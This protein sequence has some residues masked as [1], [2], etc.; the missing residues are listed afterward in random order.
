[1]T[2]FL[3]KFRLPALS[4]LPLPSLLLA[5]GIFTTLLV[6]A[7]VGRYLIFNKIDAMANQYGNALVNL[8]ARQAV[9][10]TLIHDLVSLQVILSDIAENPGVVNATIHDVENNLLVQAGKTGS[11]ERFNTGTQQNFT[12]PITL[13]DSIAGYVT[14]TVDTSD[15]APL[16]QQLYWLFGLTATLMLALFITA[17]FVSRSRE[18][19]ST[20]AT[21]PIV[22]PTTVDTTSRE[23]IKGTMVDEEVLAYQVE[24][25]WQFGNLQELNAQLSSARFRDILQRLKKHM[26]GALSLYNGQL[27]SMDLRHALMQFRGNESLANAAFQAICCARLLMDLSSHEQDFDIKHCAAIH[28]PKPGIEKVS[29]AADHEAQQILL[30]N[31]FAQ[32]SHSSIFVN[33]ELAQSDELTNKLI[34]NSDSGTA[35]VA[36]TAINEPYD[37]LVERQR[38]KLQGVAGGL[39]IV[40]A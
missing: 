24:M 14:V 35:F 36:V 21:I 29:A 23:Q 30:E 15:I 27:V 39:P 1:M 34:V 6:S 38:R 11:K 20:A 25:Q 32:T 33:A 7:A 12:A 8:A 28:A 2:S 9:D 37:A 22:N 26:Q 5:A 4:E 3:K 18:T 17:F 31:L 10:A 13:H 19:H 16:R 40:N